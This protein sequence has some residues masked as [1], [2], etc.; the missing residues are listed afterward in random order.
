[1]EKKFKHRRRANPSSRMPRLYFHDVINMFS[2]I[3][4]SAAPRGLERVAVAQQR[5]NPALENLLSQ[6]H[7]HAELLRGWLIEPHPSCERFNPSAEKY[8]R[9]FSFSNKYLFPAGSALRGIVRINYSLHSVQ[10]FFIFLR[11]VLGKTRVLGEN[12]VAKYC[13]QIWNKNLRHRNQFELYTYNYS[14]NSQHL[15]YTCLNYYS[16]YRCFLECFT[17]F[18]L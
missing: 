18:K 2:L 16:F 3:S 6:Q 11:K 12:I 10:A 8:L 5:K 4:I 1:M 7:A 17:L 13:G 9:G 14:R 15:F